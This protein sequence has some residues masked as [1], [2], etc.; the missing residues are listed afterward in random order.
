MANALVVSFEFWGFFFIISGS[1]IEVWF[2]FASGFVLCR[3]FF[4]I[5]CLCRRFWVSEYY[6]LLPVWVFLPSVGSYFLSFTLV[7]FRFFNSCGWYRYLT[8]C[9]QCNILYFSFYG[10]WWQ[11]FCVTFDNFVVKVF[12]FILCSRHNICIVTVLLSG[13]TSLRKQSHH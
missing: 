11:Y 8:S 9:F 6:F 10:S 3:F 4:L 13:P 12:G 5:L 7:I 1:N 2:S